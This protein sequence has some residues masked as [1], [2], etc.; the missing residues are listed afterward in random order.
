MYHSYNIYIIK[1]IYAQ[2][3]VDGEL[4]VINIYFKFILYCNLS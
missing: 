4:I 2:I 3:I 1:T